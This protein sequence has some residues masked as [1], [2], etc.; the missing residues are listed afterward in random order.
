[1]RRFGWVGMLAAL[2]V[3]ATGIATWAA[4]EGALAPQ[5]SHG[6]LLGA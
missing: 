5:G 4:A 6:V 2:A 1:M 3:L